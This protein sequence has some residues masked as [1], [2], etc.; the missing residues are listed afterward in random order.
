MQPYAARGRHPA[1]R[2]YPEDP[3]QDRTPF[4]QDCDRVVHTTA[5]RR[6]MHKTQVFFLPDS[7]HVRTRLTHTIEV[8]RAARS[9]ADRLGLN[10]DLAECIALAHD[11]G[12]PPFGHAGEAT[13]H[14]L[15]QD[16]GGFEHNMQALRIVTDLSRTYPDFN[17]LN[18]CRESLEGIAKHNGPIT[19]PLPADLARILDQHAIGSDGYPSAEAQVAALADDIAYNCHDL[20]DGL[21]TGILALED[22]GSLPILGPRFELLRDDNPMLDQHRMMHAL[23][24]HLFGALMDDLATGSAAILARVAPQAIEDIRQC[25]ERVIA[26]TATTE[27]ALDQIRAFLQCS[28]YNIDE[29]ARYRDKIGKVLTVIFE[30]YTSRPDSLPAH[31]RSRLGSQPDPGLIA[32]TVADYIAGMTDNFAIA[33]FA[34]IMGLAGMVSFGSVADLQG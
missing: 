32:R 7:D 34:D 13:L 23:V 8:A 5:F 22:L 12:H 31:W 18:L 2:L 21:R 30:H 33:T 6:L 27:A 1:D 15:M 3:P 20:Q 19:T 17:G 28:M 25:N 10:P 26:F 16:N 11:L 4:Q 14:D 9:I 24:R 29:M